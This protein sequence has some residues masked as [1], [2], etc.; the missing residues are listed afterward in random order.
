LDGRSDALS[1]ANLEGNLGEAGADSAW[2]SGIRWW[3]CFLADAGAEGGV[4]G[5]DST[6]AGCCCCG[7]GGLVR[8]RR[9]VGVD[10]LLLLLPVAALLTAEKNLAGVGEEH[11]AGGLGLV[12]AL[13]REHGYVGALLDLRPSAPAPPASASP[14]VEERG[15][16]GGEGLGGGE[17]EVD[18]RGRVGAGA[19]DLG[20]GMGE[21]GEGRRDCGRRRGMGLGLGLDAA[22]YTKETR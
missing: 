3:W 10:G 15:R 20:R 12:L 14:P 8:H 19:A 16:C 11:L 6:T 18:L 9:V 22:L 13:G 17:L 2:S 5:A 7:G 4:T 21:A 1:S